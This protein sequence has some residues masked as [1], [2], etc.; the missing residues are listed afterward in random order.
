MN[1]IGIDLGTCNSVV[2]LWNGN[3]VEI[4]QNV[5]DGNKVTPSIVGFKED[6]EM[7]VGRPAK[8]IG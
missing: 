6:Y 1:W 4:L 2:G 7:K 8:T 5:D 3:S